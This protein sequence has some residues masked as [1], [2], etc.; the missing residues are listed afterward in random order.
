MRRPMVFVLLAGLAAML[1]SVMVYSALKSREAQV[2]QAMAHNVQVVVAAYDLPLGTKIDLGEVKLTRWSADSIPDGAYTDPKQVIGSFVRN[3]LVANEPVVRSKLFSGDK[4]AGVMPLLIPFGM[5]AV[6]VPVDEVSDVAGFV[7]PHSRVDVLVSTQGGSTGPDRAFSK[8]VLQNVEVLAVAQ[9]VEEQKDAPTVV[10]VVTLL[11]TPQEA[12]RLALASRSGTLRLAMRNY[13]D[14]KIVLTNGT[15]T[16]Q[17]LRSYSLTPDAPVMAVKPEEPPHEAVAPPPRRGKAVEI[18]ILRNGKS[19]ESV[20]F[21]NEASDQNVA[22]AAAKAPEPVSAAFPAFPWPPPRPSALVVLPGPPIK[23][24]TFFSDADEILTRALESAGYVRRSYFSVPDGFAVATQLEQIDPSGN[25]MPG[26]LRWI[27]D[28]NL[29]G[30]F[31]LRQYLQRLFYAPI[32]HYRVIVFIVTPRA[33]S[34]Q[35]IEIT[36]SLAT[37]W[38]DT[39]TNT[40]PSIVGRSLFLDDGACTA[41]VY[42]FEQEGDKKPHERIPSLITARTHLERARLWQPLAGVQ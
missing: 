36:S 35:Q 1:A 21:V 15:D 31:T 24:G 5:R 11:V 29:Q 2:Q 16:A 39:G 38:L 32:G 25:P 3:S 8:V 34:E 26:R 20:S 10:K 7:L 27:S 42:E 22:K 9:E 12:E 14:N 40:L 33:F 41:L 30:A 28:V 17:M 19:S 37:G 4:T 18:E 23:K 6:S 13:N